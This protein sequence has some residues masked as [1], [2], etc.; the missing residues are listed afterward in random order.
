M[1]LN[2]LADAEWQSGIGE[3]ITW[4]AATR[5]WDEFE[6]GEYGDGLNELAIFLICRDPELKFKR[7]IRHL[8]KER[9]IYMDVMLEL[10]QFVRAKFVERRKFVVDALLTEVPTVVA[11][12]S[13]VN[14]DTERFIRDF[15]N[16]FASLMD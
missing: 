12:Y 14:F 6:V 1:R 5:Y 2:I 7:R 13:I 9:K 15:S 11:K 10:D 4:L 3:V 16:R 8:K